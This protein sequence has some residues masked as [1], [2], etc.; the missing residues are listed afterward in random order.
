MLERINLH[1]VASFTGTHQS[2]PSLRP[3]NFIYGANGSG[4]TTISRVIAAPDRYPSCGLVWERDVALETLVYN[5]D[6]VTDNFTSRMRGIFTLGQQDAAIIAAIEAARMEVADIQR[7][8]EART[9]TQKEKQSDLD[10]LDEAFREECWEAKVKF[11]GKFKEAFQGVLNAKASFADRMFREAND[12]KR[13]VH[14]LEDLERRAATLFG[15][16][17]QRES[18]IAAFEA[19]QFAAIHSSPVLGRSVVGKDDVDISGL[20]KRLGNSDWVKQGLQY[21]HDDRCPFCQQSTDAHFRA[22]I[23]EYFDE[24]F[25]KDIEDINRLAEDYASRSRSLLSQLDSMLANPSSYLDIASLTQLRSRFQ[26]VLSLNQQYLERKKKEPSEKVM[27]E[28]FVDIFHEI[29]D[30]ISAA[31]TKIAAHNELVDNIV[32]ERAALVGD[33]W[34]YVVE[35]SSLAIGTYRSR[36]SDLRSAIDGLG[37]GI[38]SKS[39]AKIAKQAELTELE[40]T[41]TSVQ[42]TVNAINQLLLSFGFRN[43]RL[44]TAGSDQLHYRVIRADGTDA[45]ETLSEGEK[46]FITF[47]YFYHRISG[48]VSESGTTSPRVVVFD[49]PVSSLDS[50]ILFIVSSLIKKVFDKA[51]D[52]A[53]SIKQVFV[54]THNIYFHKEVSFDPSRGTDR[55]NF[56]TFWIVKKMGDHSIVVA[57]PTNPI[58]SSY[59]MLWHEVRDD[60]RS[61]LTIQNTLRRIIENYF[62]I[63]G[64]VNRDD[65]VSMFEGEDQLVCNSLFSWINDGSHSIHEDLYLV[66]DEQTV[67][68]YLR[69]FKAI[70]EKSGHGGHYDMM[71]I[72]R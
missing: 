41:I 61:S 7:A 13:D 3:I 42:P 35:E 15:E 68:S 58:K 29:S 59:E 63:M 56:E 45:G 1:G 31:N 22:E 72:P 67:E 34:R 27:L 70:F 33:V 14:A 8:I 51:R 2:L 44:A 20:I 50:D 49:D 37:K 46:T 26:S 21:F 36:S 16:T 54:L 62:L 5:R 55:R 4:K 69:V 6:F 52:Q 64:N 47:L 17:K 57:H 12:N 38:D 53:S 10:V 30:V 66:C 28:T 23:A 48:S 19:T 25:N 43:F 32:T 18:L 40:K 71:V 39:S 24:Q 9:A 65:I 60:A 11:E